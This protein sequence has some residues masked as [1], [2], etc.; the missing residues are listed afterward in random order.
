M[1]LRN[2]SAR[3][4]TINSELDGKKVRYTIKPGD[5]PA[6]EVPDAVC[7]KEV[8]VRLLLKDKLLMKEAVAEDDFFDDDDAKVDDELAG[9]QAT[10]IG[11]GIE[12][13]ETWAVSTLKKKIAERKKEMQGN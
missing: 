12:V 4:I 13:N 11:L 3:L 1:L 10:A 5:N 8:F 7:K 6:V 2:I 9:L